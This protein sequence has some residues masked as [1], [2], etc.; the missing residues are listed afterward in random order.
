MNRK[1]EQLVGYLA[2]SHPGASITVLIKLAYLVDLVSV[3]RND[4]QISDFEYSRY[5]Y[6]PFDKRIYGVIEN[7]S[8]A[9]VLLEETD[10]TQMGSEYMVYSFNE[11]IDYP[12]TD[13]S[14]V[15]RALVD[16]VLGGVKGYGARALTEIAYKT[17]PMQALGATLGGDENLESVLN[18][19]AE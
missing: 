14:G 9:N 2:K 13:L 3:Q 6:G 19:R 1:T 18:L 5:S 7:L 11:T 17:K 10:Y 12:F 4:S 15:E 8:S 16:E